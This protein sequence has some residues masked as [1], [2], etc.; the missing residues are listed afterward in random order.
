MIRREM[1]ENW[2][3][4]PE[5][6]SSVRIGLKIVVSSGEVVQ[7][8]GVNPASV[9]HRGISSGIYSRTVTLENQ[10]K[11]LRNFSLEA[12]T[13]LLLLASSIGVRHC[14]NWR[15]FSLISGCFLVEP[16]WHD[17][18]TS[19][20]CP[21]YRMP[22]TRSTFSIPYSTWWPGSGLSISGLYLALTK[23]LRRQFRLYI[24]LH[25]STLS[26]GLDPKPILWTQLLHGPRWCDLQPHQVLTLNHPGHFRR[27]YRRVAT[28]RGL[29]TFEDRRFYK[30]CILMN[31]SIC[32]CINV[33][34][35]DTDVG[36]SFIQGNYP[37][38]LGEYNYEIQDRIYISTSKINKKRGNVCQR[39]RLDASPHKHIGIHFNP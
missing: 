15:P 16:L 8:G 5:S 13:Y 17:L 20:H 7:A 27:F 1:E 25:L 30:L 14:Q 31:F 32:S 11:I 18:S 3:W 23:N 22:P 4:W 26:H 39:P 9:I 21:A 36:S 10:Q 29:D 19:N 28:H 2:L 35:V 6:I 12:C 34:M 33:L 38:L 37:R 24:S